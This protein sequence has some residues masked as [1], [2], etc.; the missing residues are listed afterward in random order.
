VR[1]LAR[2]SGAVD[3]AM[4]R[5]VKPV[6]GAWIGVCRVGVGL[7]SD[8]CMWVVAPWSQALFGSDLGGHGW[9]FWRIRMAL[10]A[11]VELINSNEMK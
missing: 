7:V 4:A 1:V 5:E 10:L 6:V 11:W 9:A 3:A 8:F 2:A